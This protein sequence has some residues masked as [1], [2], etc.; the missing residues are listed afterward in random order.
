MARSS[1][2]HEVGLKVSKKR[3]DKRGSE[4]RW[5]EKERRVLY[6]WPIALAQSYDQRL[7]LDLFSSITV[8]A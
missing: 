6:K 8:H 2:I 1:V 7:I 3:G 4:R 5:R